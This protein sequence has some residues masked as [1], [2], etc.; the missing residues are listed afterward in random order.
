MDACVLKA[1][2]NFINSLYGFFS[3]C[4]MVF[5]YITGVP[6]YLLR[7]LSSCTKGGEERGGEENIVGGG[8]GNWNKITIG[9]D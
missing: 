9:V 2:I 6:T 1:I 8:T 3:A 4:F 7:D 5:Y